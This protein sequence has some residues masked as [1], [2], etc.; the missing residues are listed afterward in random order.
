MNRITEGAGNAP[1]I[2]EQVIYINNAVIEGTEYRLEE[3]CGPG[4]RGHIRTSYGALVK[5]ESLCEGYARAMKAVLDSMGITSVLVQGYYQEEDGSR[6][7]HMWNYVQ[8]DGKWYGL[9]A[10][11]NDGMSGSSSQDTYLLADGSVMEAHHIPDGVMSPGGVCF[12]YPQLERSQT[13]NPDSGNTGTE[14]GGETSPDMGRSEE[15]TSELQSP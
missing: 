8:I 5:G 3:E 11:A 2:R 14:E 13:D 4:N 1:T 15:H 12:T 7:L 9:D 10:T 6:K